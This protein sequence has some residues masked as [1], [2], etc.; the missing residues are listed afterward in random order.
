[1]PF[2]PGSPCPAG[3]LHAPHVMQPT[4]SLKP[5]LPFPL[6]AAATHTHA[7]RLFSAFP[8]MDPMQKALLAPFHLHLP[9]RKRHVISC[10]VCQLRFNSES[11]ATAHYKGGKHAKRLKALEISKAKQAG[12]TADQA[13]REPGKDGTTPAQPACAPTAPSR[14]DGSDLA[15]TEEADGGPLLAESASASL[16]AQ[17]SASDGADPA[18]GGGVVSVAA[19][20]GACSVARGPL[21]CS[22]AASTSGHA[23]EPAEQ[24]FA[25]AVPRQAAPSGA[26]A[27]ADSAVALGVAPPG[28][29]DLGSSREGGYGGLE[30][31][32][33]GATVPCCGPTETDGAKPSKLSPALPSST[34]SGAA[35]SG[36]AEDAKACGDA[37]AKDEEDKGG[38]AKAEGDEKAKAALFCSLCKV[39]LNSQSQMEAHNNGSMH[40]T[41][42]EAQSGGG[43]I[44]AYPR[45]G[46]R[47]AGP[48]TADPSGL[49][50]KVFHCEMCDVR[51][52]SETQL[53]Q[54]IT[55]RRHKDR[56]AGKP[57]KPKFSPYTRLPCTAGIISAKLAFPKDIGKA[58]APGFFATAAPALTPQLT[59][60]PSPHHH[61]SLFSAGPALLRPAPG[62]M[63]TAH[64]SILFAPY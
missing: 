41:L 21:D 19:Q 15:P 34:R 25:G 8:A 29:D 37:A 35:S 7:L 4:L 54:H 24:D 62:P 42:L 44:K 3:P 18:P 50:N 30:R 46:S 26:A 32:G 28:P 31:S 52:N 59:L 13:E 53:K 12:D 43:S 14:G 23:D 11:Q 63:R 16:Q 20:P 55:S 33:T 1:M 22:G 47:S 51:V 6:E 36:P 61:A 56:V 10:N 27:A 17:R 48:G 40:K 2:I 49:Q 5:F 57:P 38:D 9:P 45:P 64:G 58:V 60:R 39:A